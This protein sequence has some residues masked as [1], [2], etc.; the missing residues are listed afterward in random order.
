VRNSLLIACAFSCVPGAAIAQSFPEKQ[1][2]M[3]FLPIPAVMPQVRSGK[4]RVLAVTS[5][6]RCAAVP[7]IPTIDESGVAGYEA[8]SWNALLAPAATPRDIIAKIQSAVAESLRAPRVKEVLTNAGAEA[9]GS[10]PEAFGKFLH[11][12]IAKWALVVKNARIKAE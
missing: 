10:T 9:V 1:V 5:T 2:A 8:N 12:E 4:L 6:K 7:D 3:S 11:D